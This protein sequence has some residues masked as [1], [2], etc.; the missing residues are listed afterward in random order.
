MNATIQKIIKLGTPSRMPASISPMLCTLVKEPI[1]DQRFIYEVKWDGYR[2]ISYVNNGKVRMDSRSGLDYTKKYPPLVKALLD[3]KI[4]AVLDGEAVVLNEKGNPDFDALQRFNGHTDPISYYVFDILWIEGYDMMELPLV[5]RKHVLRS[6]LKNSKIIRFSEDF[7]DGKGLFL[8][9]QE[10]DLEGIVAKVRD[11]PYNPGER[12]RNWY[13][14]PTEKR[15]EFV[16]GGWTESDKGRPFASLLFGAYNNKKL[17]WIGHAGGGFKDAEMPG[18]L[19]KLK[20]KEIKDSPFI[21]KVDTNG[22][23]HWSKPVL[24]GNFKFATWTKSGRIRKPAIFLGFR[25]DKKA[26]DVTREIP[27]DLETATRQV[28]KKKRTGTTA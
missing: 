22:V 17:E 8:K 12:G 4:D 6:V 20:L 26:T 16:I 10:M 25:K 3:L 28:K 13:K 11:S 1:I 7:E 18:I 27:K 14:T 9:M 23:A 19:E 21:N 2:I 5:K 15:Q 24:V